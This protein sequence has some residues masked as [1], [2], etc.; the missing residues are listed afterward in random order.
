MPLLRLHHPRN[1]VQRVDTATSRTS[2]E[3]LHVHTYRLTSRLPNHI[4]RLN[5]SPLRISPPYHT[6]H[7]LCPIAA[8]LNNYLA[9][10]SKDTELPLTSK[11]TYLC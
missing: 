1:Y 9:P 8:H 11:V 10:H 2:G 6:S 3:D 4:S 5:P 7:L